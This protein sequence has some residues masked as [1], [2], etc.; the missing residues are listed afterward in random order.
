MKATTRVLIVFIISAI[1]ST[2]FFTISALVPV[3]RMAYIVLGVIAAMTFF[4]AFV[5]WISVLG[6]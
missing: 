4:I 6:G 3:L 1:L 5:I 2:I